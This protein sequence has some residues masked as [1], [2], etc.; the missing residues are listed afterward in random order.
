[1]GRRQ[2][3]EQLQGL[4]SEKAYVNFINSLR[5]KATIKVYRVLIIHYL[6]FM[7][8]KSSNISTLLNHDARTIE[9]QI[10]SY[11]VH[12]R[13]NQKL[14]YSS[15][16]LRLAVLRRFYEMNDV[17]INWKKVSN[18]LG[19]NIKLFKDRAYTTEEIQRLLTR[20]DERI[21]VVIL[22]L[23]STGMRI[24]AIPSL[25]L[26]HLTKVEDYNLYQI[27]VY[28]NTKDEYYCFCSPECAIAIDSYIAYRER[29]YEKVRPESPLIREQFDRDNPDK[30]RSPR[31]LPLN[32]LSVLLRK[33][34]IVAGIRS[35]EH[36]TE[37]KTNGRLRKE[38]KASHGFRKFV[39]TNMIR[40]K[41]NPEAREMLL[42]HSI[43]LSDSYYR[44]DV[45][46]IL[47]EYLKA[48]DLLT[49]N[50]ENRLRRKIQV[51]EVKADKIE[52]L[53]RTIDDVKN[54]LG[55]T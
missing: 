27:T 49:I 55:L 2:E 50:D 3:Q 14:S 4:Q 1:M 32:T 26:K 28:E 33:L 12:L 23:A 53:Q 45:N 17:I 9:E 20:A 46:E 8:I 6:R 39:T 18:Y 47:T 13:T 51:L 22:L 15:L 42:G 44:P 54:K 21:R 19:E 30:A 7:N 5:S 41:V 43:G 36:L 25:K 29:C 24:G 16:A 40:A 52:E 34:L 31:L 35:I 10:I 11:L 48:V 38:V 37:T